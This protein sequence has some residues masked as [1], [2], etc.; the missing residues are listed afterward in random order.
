VEFRT[1]DLLVILFFLGFFV[2][3]FVQGAIRRAL[4]LASM[5]FSFLFAASVSGPLGSFLARNWTQ[6]PQEY[7]YMV[8][9]GTVFLAATIAFSLTIQGFY[10]TQPLFEKARFVDE[11]LGGLIGLIQ[12]AFVTGAVIVILDSFFR[13]PTIP[14]FSRE[15][16]FLREIW[17]AI[18]TSQTAE[19]FRTT[20]IPAFFS[21][22][23]PFIPDSLRTMFPGRG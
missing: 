8:G 14:P 6:F 2:L 4:G 5:V 17:T 1:F 13:I 22:A 16:P 12:A 3:G 10:K 23:G 18:D 11:L 7:S 21:V 9:F 20:M 19:V 15:L